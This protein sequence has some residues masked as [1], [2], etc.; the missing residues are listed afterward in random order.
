MDRE[1]STLRIC[2]SSYR[3]PV[4]YDVLRHQRYQLLVRFGCNNER[5]IYVECRELFVP[6][7]SQLS[8]LPN[9]L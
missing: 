9:D 4:S 6:S 8:E 2:G 3:L 5:R 1:A 7:I